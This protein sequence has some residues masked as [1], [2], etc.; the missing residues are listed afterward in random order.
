MQLEKIITLAN[1]QVEIPFLA[2]ERSLRKTGC[3]LPLWVIPYSDDTFEL[4]AGAVWWKDE[5]VCDWIQA[6][7]GCP[8]MRKYQCMLE[9][10]YQFIDSDAIFLRNPATVLKPHRGWVASCCHWHNPGHTHTEASMQILH[11]KSTV[12][13][14]RV[15]NTG[16]FACDR[17][18]YDF[19]ALCATAKDPRYR[20]TILDNPFHEQPGINL[21]VHLT[22]VAIHN[23]TLPPFN[24]ESTWAGDY[25][26]AYERYW[27]NPDKKPYLIHWAGK[28]MDQT[29]P[30]DQ[31]FYA[32]LTPEEARTYN[33]NLVDKPPK[34]RLTHQLKKAIRTFREG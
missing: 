3:Q 26:D 25:P 12:W 31:L 29:C 33:Q 13:Q 1:K 17:A 30:I 2:M 22:D 24:M 14:S 16:Q 18:L 4:P 19:D 9:A 5:K 23:L 20:S 7:N 6:Q 32:F 11:R 8:V 34:R 27:T 21:L 10:N 15:F 28:K